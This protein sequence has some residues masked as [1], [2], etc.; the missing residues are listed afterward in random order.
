MGSVKDLILPESISGGWHSKAAALYERPTSHSFG[1]GGWKVSGRF[2]VG[3]LKGI[4]P[5]EYEIKD[6]NFVLAM[7]AGAYFEDAANNDMQ[8]CYEGMMNHD[9]KV[10]SVRDLL[11]KGELSDVIVMKL[12]NV[13]K[14][15]SKEDVAA[16]HEA[17]R[18]R[19]ISVYVADVEAIFRAGLPLGSSVFKKICGM[20]GKGD[21]YERVATYDDTVALLD[22]VRAESLKNPNP[23]LITYLDSLGL[24]GIPNP[25]AML[26]R[27][28]F[29][30]TTKF[31]ESGDA[32]IGDDDVIERLG[33]DIGKSF[34]LIA[35]LGHC[36]NHQLAYSKQR[37]S[38]N[39]DG[40]IEGVVMG[41]D[42]MLT[43]F[44]CTVDENRQMLRYEHNGVVYLLPTNK[45]IQ[46]AVFR[47]NGIYVAIEEA[48]KIDAEKWKPHLLKFTTHEKLV[49]ATRH[50][51][52]LM[53]GAIGTM[54]NLALGKN[55]FDAK[56]LDT[57]APAFLPYASREQDKE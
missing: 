27:P 55:I 40:K 3:D 35:L 1:R 8:S 45:E 28:A 25:G 19:D 47:E 6:K 17:I 7:T 4:I 52:E 39:M 24:D 38:N 54:G 16:Y 36:T 34:K 37:G 9:G 18:K 48:K 14:S 32:D 43:D 23:K 20:M 11:D 2:S 21:Q 5:H 13:P 44:A 49:D 42:V 29:N 46:R 31:A 53:S 22:E 41:D 57:W 30:Y 33:G 56:P 15:G 12:A 50:S 26:P 51:V 10:V